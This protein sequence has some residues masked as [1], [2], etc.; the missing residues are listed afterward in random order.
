MLCICVSSR[1]TLINLDIFNRLVWRDYL[2]SV[3]FLNC[4][5]SLPG[6]GLSDFVRTDRVYSVLYMSATVKCL[7]INRILIEMAELKESFYLVLYNF[8]K[9]YGKLEQSF[10]HQQ[11]FHRFLEFT[12]FYSVFLSKSC[13]EQKPR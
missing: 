3:S 6:Y 4:F 13:S 12:K 7:C 2:F 8:L 9:P 11:Q 1:K 10:Y 5:I